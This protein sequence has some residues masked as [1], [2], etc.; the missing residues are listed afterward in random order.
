MVQT[1]NGHI[2]LKLKEDDWTL[3]YKPDSKISKINTDL[4]LYVS[5]TF[6]KQ[7]YEKTKKCWYCCDQYSYFTFSNHKHII[8]Y[9]Q[10]S[11]TTSWFL[12]LI[13]ENL[14]MHTKMIFLNK[15]VIHMTVQNHI[16]WIPFFYRN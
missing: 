7:K 1:G 3:K 12:Q 6:M 2:G 10:Q 14:L 5:K 16:Q 13:Y 15:L 9:T 8:K 4:I 11:N